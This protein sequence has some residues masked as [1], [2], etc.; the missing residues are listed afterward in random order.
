MASHLRDVKNGE[1]IVI[2]ERNVPIAELIP[3]RENVQHP[4]WKRRIKRI[5]N[6]GRSFVSNLEEE[7]YGA[8]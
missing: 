8:E 5:K 2:L 4:A 3:Y 7:R 1:R 6:T